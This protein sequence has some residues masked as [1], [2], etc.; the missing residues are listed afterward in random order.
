MRARFHRGRSRLGTS[1]LSGV[2]DGWG[3]VKIS[4]ALALLGASFLLL[5]MPQ[6]ALA[7]FV[8]EEGQPFTGEVATT[9]ALSVCDVTINWDDGQTSDGSASTDTTG[10]VIDGTHTYVEDGIYHGTATWDTVCGS[11]ATTPAAAPLNCGTTPNCVDFVATVLDAPIGA[12]SVPVSTVAGTQFSGSVATLNDA[13]PFETAQSYSVTI[14]WGDNTPS[15]SGTV[16][17]AAGGGF[18]VAGTHMFS[19]PGS[20]HVTAVIVDSGGASA[21]AVS[22]AL[23]T[24]AALPACA[25]VDASTRPDSGAAWI[26]LQCSGPSGGALAYSIDSPPAH[27]TLGSIDQ[28]T[29]SVAYIADP[30][31][32]GVDTLTYS[33]SA[34]GSRSG[35]AVATITVRPRAPSCSDLHEATPGQRISI[36]LLLPCEGPSGASVEYSIVS[37][38]SHGILRPLGGTVGGFRYTPMGAFSGT[39]H[40]V[41]AATDSGGRSQTAVATIAVPLTGPTMGWL[42]DPHVNYTLIHAL[43]VYDVPTGAKV[44]SFCDGAGCPFSNHRGGVV[45]PSVCRHRVCGPRAAPGTRTIDLTDLFR[46]RHLRVGTRMTISIGKA[47]TIGKAYIFTM[48]SEEQPAWSLACVAPGFARPAESC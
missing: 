15:S 3:K 33:A 44:R 48:R 32:Y 20:Y 34:W 7:D 22:T 42:F 21:T 31:Y 13:N 28:G 40:F 12:A 39:D 16:A 46:S 26:P 41:Y 23:V 17:S 24:S 35:P 18:T 5:V 19:A 1:C 2:G 6:V 11:P 10:T 30:G 29:G 45:V 36:S 47:Q 27:G 4:K 14:D 37:R 9:S 25:N 38:P 8:A 43:V